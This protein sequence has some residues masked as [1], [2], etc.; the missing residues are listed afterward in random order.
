LNPQDL[1]TTKA[2]LLHGGSE[3]ALGRDP[4]T[5]D[6]A[7]RTNWPTF[8]NRGPFPS[9]R[10]KR[11]VPIETPISRDSCL[12][13]SNV[14]ICVSFIVLVPREINALGTSP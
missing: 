6:G 13:L 2:E 14:S 11:N 12:S 3:T 1:K 10:Q 5:S 4:L 9:P 8:R 7:Y